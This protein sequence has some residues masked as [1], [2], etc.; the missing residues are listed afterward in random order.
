M[1]SNRGIALGG[2]PRGPSD[3]ARCREHFGGALARVRVAE[4]QSDSWTVLSPY[5]CVTAGPKCR[6]P[7]LL[8]LV[9]TPFYGSVA[10]LWPVRAKTR[11]GV[12][13]GAFFAAA[14]DMSLRIAA[15][16]RLVALASRQFGVVNRADL[17]TI[18]V[19][20]KWLRGRLATGE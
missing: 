14:K 5:A 11:H 12:V 17:A 7:R 19:S 9:F 18:E 15:G 1:A 10:S 8:E 20:W 3:R 6:A 16:R 4:L 13:D 2:M